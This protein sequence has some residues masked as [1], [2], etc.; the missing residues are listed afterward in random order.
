MTI[1]EG[2]AQVLCAQILKMCETSIYSKYFPN[3]DNIRK[4]QREF[5]ELICLAVEANQMEIFKAEFATKKNLNFELRPKTKSQ[6]PLITTFIKTVDPHLQQLLFD[7]QLSTYNP[8]DFDHLLQVVANLSN[9]VRFVVLI[10]VTTYNP[11][12]IRVSTFIGNVE[13]RLQISY[14]SDQGRKHV[15]DFEKKLQEIVNNLPPTEMYV[16]TTHQLHK[17]FIKQQYNSR[18]MTPSQIESLITDSPIGG[19]RKSLKWIPSSDEMLKSLYDHIDGKGYVFDII[20]PT[21]VEVGKLNKFRGMVK[22]SIG[23][24]WLF[25][26]RE[27][28]AED[29]KI[30][31]D[32][33]TRNEGMIG[34]IA[35][36]NINKCNYH[37]NVIRLAVKVENLLDLRFTDES[38]GI[39]KNVSNI[40]KPSYDKKRHC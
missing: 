1:T 35:I 13:G 29:V 40:F 30:F 3:W 39:S 4:Y 25:L 27:S 22:P 31:C 10:N 18:T 21:L 7:Y 36:F 34:G 28:K 38:C 6:L 2:E 17:N 26:P 8:N 11:A 19:N 33:I 20:I 24:I 16:S 12:A 32:A 9:K 5:T 37:E 14:R 23:W 15:E